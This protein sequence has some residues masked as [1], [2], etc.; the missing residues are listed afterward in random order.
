MT[1]RLCLEHGNGDVIPPSNHSHVWIKI[2]TGG[3]GMK[4]NQ[5]M[6]Q[7]KSHFYVED[8]FIRHM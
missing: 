6:N 1:L 4:T 8:R 2:K 5:V 3:N 7:I